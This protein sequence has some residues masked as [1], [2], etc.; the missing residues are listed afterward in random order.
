MRWVKIESRINHETWVANCGDMGVL[1]RSVNTNSHDRPPQVEAESM[2]FVP[3]VRCE[4]EEL[5]QMPALGMADLDIPEDT[6]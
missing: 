3:G 1:I 2:V 4:G 5:V 6:D